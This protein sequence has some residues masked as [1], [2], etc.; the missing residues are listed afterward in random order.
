LHHHNYAAP[1][2]RRSCRTRVGAGRLGTGPAFSLYLKYLWR[3]KIV[4][5][6]PPLCPVD[7]V[8]LKAAGI[9]G[10]WTKCESEEQYV[11]WIDKLNEKAEPLGLAEWENRIW[12]EWFLAQKQRAARSHAVA[13]IVRSRRSLHTQT[14]VHRGHR[15]NLAGDIVGAESLAIRS[16]PHRCKSPLGGRFR[17]SHIGRFRDRCTFASDRML[18][19]TACI[20]SSGR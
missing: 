14:E 7:R 8:V 15:S 1:S 13:R 11:E 17:E 18:L 5:V 3:L 19:S 2:R 12:L 16:P 9:D 10:S 6:P 4:V 20:L